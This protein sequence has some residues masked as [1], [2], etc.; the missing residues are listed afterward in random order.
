MALCTQHSGVQ[1]PA[2]TRTCHCQRECVAGPA[3]HGGTGSALLPPLWSRR[4]PLSN[5]RGV[6]VQ[7]PWE[8][9]RGPR[10]T[11]RGHTHTPL[12]CHSPLEQV[13]EGGFAH[14]VSA[15]CHVKHL[16][17]TSPAGRSPGSPQVT[18]IPTTRLPKI[19]L[20]TLLH[21]P[22]ADPVFSSVKWGE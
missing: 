12:S 14:V 4:E 9:F 13:Q 10:G 5:S 18:S 15:S 19:C 16:R 2:W 6:L 3:G 8:V 21:P 17:A 11:K 1:G 22:L 7:E 20:V